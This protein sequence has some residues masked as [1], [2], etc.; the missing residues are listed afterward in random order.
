MNS[1]FFIISQKTNK[2][3]LLR[4]FVFQNLCQKQKQSLINAT[5]SHYVLRGYG[6]QLHEVADFPEFLTSTM[7]LD[8]QNV[9]SSTIT[10]ADQIEIILDACP[11][12]ESIDTYFI[13]V[14]LLDVRVDKFMR[15]NDERWKKASLY[16]NDT[17]SLTNKIS[18]LIQ[19]STVDPNLGATY[20]YV[21]F[22]HKSQLFTELNNLTDCLNKLQTL[23]APIKVI[24][25]L[26]WLASLF[27][28]IVKKHEETSI[29]INHNEFEK[30]L[31]NLT[32]SLLLVMQN[33]Y[34]KYQ[35]CDK[36]SKTSSEVDATEDMGLQENHLKALLADN[37]SLDIATLD[38]KQISKNAGKI[39]KIL[40]DGAAYADE[41]MRTQI[42]RMIPLYD[43]I[44]Q[45]SQY[46]I[47]QQVAAYRTTCKLT[48]VLLNIFIDLAS[49]V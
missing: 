40:L 13:E 46:F 14:P 22:N 30:S 42:T 23:F 6:K 38:L 16:L 5:R 44:L 1:N 41:K 43:Q 10:I 32:K 26:S 28:E 36:T 49:K 35:N 9:L 15:K 25:S 8:I 45:L 47:T 2:V 34:K 20:K 17:K 18:H 7:L 3:L 33:I 37:L 21:P 27:D 48:S 24:D 4:L 39:V 29:P 19:R 31:S 12:N 11:A